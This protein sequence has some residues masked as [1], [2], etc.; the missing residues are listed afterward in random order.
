MNQ[1]INFFIDLFSSL[2]IISLSR[3]LQLIFLLFIFKT[4]VWSLK[5][6][7]YTTVEIKIW[8]WVSWLTLLRNRH[9]I[10]KLSIQ[11]SNQTEERRMWSPYLKEI[12]F[13]IVSL[14]LYFWMSYLMHNDHCW[15]LLWE[16]KWNADLHKEWTLWLGKNQRNS[17]FL[18]FCS[19]INHLSALE[20][21]D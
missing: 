21:L 7:Q 1:T 5:I 10:L 18:L 6:F 12:T 8:Y 20:K 4:N 14:W 3:L 19:L 9:L 2:G 16:C 17:K 13:V 15:L 11:L